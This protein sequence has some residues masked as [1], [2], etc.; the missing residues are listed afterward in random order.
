MHFTQSTSE[1]QKKFNK[2]NKDLFKTDLGIPANIQLNKNLR[3]DVRFILYEFFCIILKVRDRYKKINKEK[4]RFFY[5][6]FG[7]TFDFFITSNIH[8]KL[9][10]LNSK[11]QT[12][13]THEVFWN[14]LKVRKRYK[15]VWYTKN[16]GFLM[17]NSRIPSNLISHK[18][19]SVR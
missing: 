1:A 17:V 5:D 9:K 13:R 11:P 16:V 15:K 7:G 4:Y 8:K 2:Q 14:F 19:E 12:Q 18:T 3:H 6:R 10:I